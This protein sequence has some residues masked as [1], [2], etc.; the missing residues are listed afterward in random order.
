[1]DKGTLG[2]F[3]VL[4]VLVL[5]LVSGVHAAEFKLTAS[6]GAA[7]DWFGHSVAIAGDYAL[8]G[9]YANDDNG[10][11][12]GSAYIFTWDGF[13]WTQQAKLLASDGAAIDYFGRS[14]AIAGDGEY[15]LVGASG[16]DSWSGSAYIF[17]RDGTSWNELQKLTASDGAAG[18]WFSHSV[19][20]ACDGE[21]ALVGAMHD[22]DNGYNSG[23]AYIYM[24]RGIEVPAVTLTGLIALVSALS[25]IATVTLVRKRR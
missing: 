4:V 7:E 21:Y 17:K 6:D 13:S 19:A 10:S 5:S 12:S 25:A 9:A 22:D 16:D 23:S 20:I 24:L 15:A 3:S 11:A 1:M 18:D 8:V 14:V 2:L